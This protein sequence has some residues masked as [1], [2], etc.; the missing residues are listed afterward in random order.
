MGRIH[1]ILGL[2]LLRMAEWN[3]FVELCDNGVAT[4]RMTLKINVGRLFGLTEI[5]A[6]LNPSSN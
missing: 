2:I 6:V 4:W 3:H 1:Y 5:H